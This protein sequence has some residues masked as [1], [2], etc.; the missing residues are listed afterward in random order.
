MVSARNV[1][2]VTLANHGCLVESARNVTAMETSTQVQLE[3]AIVSLENAS[4][5]YTRRPD[6]IVTIAKKATL[7]TPSTEHVEVCTVSVFCTFNLWCICFVSC[8]F[9]GFISF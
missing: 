2:T 8:A 5:V 4:T 1:Q 6:F 3:S 9:I 7:E